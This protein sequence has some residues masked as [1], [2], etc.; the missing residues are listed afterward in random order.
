VKISALFATER[1]VAKNMNTL[2]RIRL[3]HVGGVLLPCVAM[4]FGSACAARVYS[5]SEPAGVYPPTVQEDDV[6]YVETV[7]PNIEAYPHYSYGG[8]EAYY[9]DGRWYRRG[10]R[11]WGY[12]RQEPPELE[13]QRA[14]V[15]REA[16]APAEHRDRPEIERAPAAPRERAEERVPVERPAA[17][18]ERA[19]ERVPVERPAAPREHAA[20]RAP[21]VSH[22]SPGSGEA[23]HPPADAPRRAPPAPKRPPPPKE[24]DR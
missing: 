9:I 14:H 17:P 21:V 23:Q 4:T 2:H 13:R 20:E 15:V 8:G 12:Y 24:H 5:Q 7:P 22:P 18:R 16:P 11:G 6:V 10:P 19:E 1:K 3:A